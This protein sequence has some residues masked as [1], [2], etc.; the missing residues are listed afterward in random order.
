MVES[1]K[2]EV[3]N[4]LHDGRL[5]NN[6]TEAT[7]NTNLS[8]TWWAMEARRSGASLLSN[9]MLVNYQILSFY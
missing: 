5:T 1:R 4:E 2:K 9:R 7:F 8:E 6:P 3:K